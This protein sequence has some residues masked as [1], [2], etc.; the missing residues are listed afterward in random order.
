MQVARTIFDQLGGNKFIA[1][2]GAKNL[3]GGDDYLSMK[4]GKNA[5][6]ANYLKIT[7]KP[8]DWYE[9]EF[10]KYTKHK[11]K[12]DHNNKVIGYTPDKL[13]TIKTIDGV[14]CDQLQEVFTSVTGMN[15][16]L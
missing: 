8:L 7:L 11:I 1:M 6:G 5:S 12:F 3:V 2:T 14:Y 9:L 10:T 13:E 15:T 4:I 16:Y